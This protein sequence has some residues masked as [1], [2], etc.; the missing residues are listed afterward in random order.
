MLD[1]LRQV[2]RRLNDG[3]LRRLRR[4][5]GPVVRLAES[6]VFGG[7]A[8]RA[9]LQGLWVGHMQSSIRRD[10]WWADADRDLH[11]SPTTETFNV[12]ANASQTLNVQSF[13]R[14]FFVSQVVEPGD[15]VLDIGC[16]EGFFTKRF[17]SYNASRVDAID[18]EP[19]AIQRALQRNA[20]PKV[21]FFQGDAVTAEL[22][23][24]YDVIVW[25][26]AIG[27][28][29]HDVTDAMLTSIKQRLSPGGIF[30]GSESLGHVGGDHL[31][32]WDSLDDLARLFKSYFEHADLYCATYRIGDHGEH[33]RE[34]AYWRCGQDR[35][36]LD[37]LKW[38]H[39]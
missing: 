9:V 3:Q 28:F 37:R 39:Y 29:S 16:G 34:E 36:R 13:N 5:G 2:K 19:G 4:W 33:V 14:A 31:Q 15:T 20:D 32:F 35:A 21:R 7:R 10:L 27:H 38:Q 6:V 1:T 11:F 26:G 23:G 8:R 17:Y 30:C 12:F 18:I 25:D 24:R 22:P